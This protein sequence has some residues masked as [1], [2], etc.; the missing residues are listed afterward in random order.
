M[1]DYETFTRDKIARLRADAD[2]LEKNLK[3]FL[4]TQARKSGAARRSGPDQPRSGAF[5]VVLEAIAAAGEAGLDLNQMTQAA[6]DEGYDIHR[7]TLRS[8]VWQAK[9]DGLLQQLEPGKYRLS[10]G[11]EASSVGIFGQI[12][13]ILNQVDSKD[14][15]LQGTEPTGARESFTADLDDE[16]PF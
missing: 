6:A 9:K 15:G 8:Q 12:A 14:G 11:H 4:A 7:P 10:T 1:D 3:E 5:G 13:R 2:A 16:I